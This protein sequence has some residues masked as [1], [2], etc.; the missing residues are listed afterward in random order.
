[1]ADNSEVIWYTESKRKKQADMIKSVIDEEI[2]NVPCKG[3]DHIKKSKKDNNKNLGSSSKKRKIPDTSKGY[4]HMKK[5]KKDSNN[6]VS[7]NN[8]RKISEIRNELA[9]SKK[10]RKMPERGLD[11][12]PSTSPSTESTWVYDPVDVNWQIE[13]ANSLGLIIDSTK[14]VT[15]R[16]S[17]RVSENE[18]F[19]RTHKT[20]GDGNCF[21]RA[22]S[23]YLTGTDI[24]HEILRSRL[25]EHLILNMEQFLRFTGK[26][27][28]EFLA[29]IDIM[30]RTTGT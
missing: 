2:K 24:S 10:K 5:F 13:R 4:E 23:M 17:R 12:L 26:T 7:S 28:T 29:Y 18:K 25:I 3:Y 22:I 11:L 16:T 19:T 21:F 15:N 1:M 9:L 14:Y 30:K 6:Q 8:K 27:A 20:K